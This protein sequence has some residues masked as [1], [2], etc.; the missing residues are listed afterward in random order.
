MCQNKT[1]TGFGFSIKNNHRKGY[2]YIRK[3]KKLKFFFKTV[4]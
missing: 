2:S 3:E 1:V 4:F